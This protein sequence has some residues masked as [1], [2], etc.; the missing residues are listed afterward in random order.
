LRGKVAL[1]TCASDC[2][3]Q[4][5]AK[6]LAQEGLRIVLARKPGENLDELAFQLREE[7][8]EVQVFP[9]DLSREQSAFRLL[10]QVQGSCGPVKIL[11]NHADLQWSDGRQPPAW[12]G[13]WTRIEHNVLGIVRL[14][15]L[16]VEQ[17]KSGEGGQVIFVE[18][19]LKLFPVR[20]TPLLHAVRG[21]FRVFAHRLGGEL[22]GTRVRVSLVKAGISTT[23]LFRLAPLRNL[24]GRRSTH[25]LEVR[26]EVLANRIWSLVIRPQRIIYVPG[27]MALFSWMEKY[28]GWLVELIRDRLLPAR[29]NPAG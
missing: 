9:T 6:R 28:A 21:F 23:E 8:G 26:P 4:A 29:A 7:G 27:L 10:E 22:R 14:T 5:A 16:V 20:P 11:V 24:L 12:R 18:P 1:V 17:M 3:G 25:G 13:S 15:E 2:F 19:A